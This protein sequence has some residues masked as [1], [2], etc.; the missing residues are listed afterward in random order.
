MPEENSI[1]LKL[2]SFWAQQA[3]VWFAQAEAQFALRNI[4]TE[5]TK[6]YHVV[7]ALPEDVASRVVDFLASPPTD[8]KY[9][10]LKTRL[11]S[12]YTLSEYERAGQLLDQHN[13][14]D[15]KPSALMDK[16]LSLLGD[17][18]PCFLFRSLFL[19]SLPAE[20]RGPLLHSKTIDCR[21]LALEADTLWNARVDTN[22]VE[23]PDI[24]ATVRN[25]QATVMRPR[26]RPRPR[27]LTFPA[28][29]DSWQQQ[30][31]GPCV[32]HAYY[33][34]QARNCTEPCSFAS[35]T[36]GNANAGRV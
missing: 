10:E 6:Y 29:K 8:N 16:M 11:L 32:F 20:I 15:G 5:D 27:G 25:K 3:K 2:P 21:Q 34:T 35:K 36:P 23:A 28:F 7:T 31:G 24:N 12:T 13:L 30:T 1:T 4:K 14:G 33:G 17:H 9:T 22:S 26:G 18:D 19:R